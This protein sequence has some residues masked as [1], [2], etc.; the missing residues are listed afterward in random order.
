VAVSIFHVGLPLDHSTIPVE[1]RARLVKR[2]SELRERMRAAGYEYE[3]VHC[4]PEGGLDSLRHKLKTEHCDG[5]LLG[6]GVVG[7]P[8]LRDFM[9]QIVDAVHADAPRAKVMLHSHAEDVRVTVERW[10]G[11]V[12]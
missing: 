1:D 8:E 9:E 6:G 3:I 11:P 10:L 2:L 4:S 12:G 7:N 5:V